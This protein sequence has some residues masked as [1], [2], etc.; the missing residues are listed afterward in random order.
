MSRTAARPRLCGGGQRRRPV[1][2]GIDDGERKRIRKMLIT[3]T[4][5]GALRIVNGDDKAR[6]PRRYVVA[7]SA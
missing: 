5:S 3:W 1:G 6:R 4:A 2:V 7:G